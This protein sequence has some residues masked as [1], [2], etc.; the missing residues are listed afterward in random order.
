MGRKNSPSAKKELVT[1]IT[2]Y[3]EA[4][5]ENRQLYLDADQLA[6]IADWYA[7]ERK[8]EEAQEVITYG[9]KIHPRNTDLLI[10]QAY[11]YLDTQKLQKAKKVADSITEE[12]DSEVKLLKAELLLNGGKL[13]EAQWLLS[14]I[15]DADEL[16][17]IIDVVFLYLDMGYPD[18]AKEWLDRGKSRYAEDEEYMALTADYLA[19]THQ[20]ESAIIYYNKLIDKSPFNP[21]YWMGLVKCYFVQEQIDKAIEA[22]D[23]ALAADESDGEAYTTKAHSFFQLNNFDKSIENYKKAMEYK[24]ISPDMGYMFIGLCYGAKEDWEKANEYYDKVIDFL[25][26]SNG[27]ESALSID[28]YTNKANALAELG[29]YKEAHQTCKKISKIHPKDATILLTEG[30]IY[31]LER[32]LEKARICF[33]KL[34]DI[35][36]SIDM[37]YM[38]ACAYMENNYEIESQYYLEKVYAL[39]PKF[40]DVAEKL[41]V[42][43][44]AYGDIESFFKYNN[45][46]AHPVTEEALSDLINYACQ[47]EEQR[48]IFKKI[49]ARMKKEKKESK[50]N[51]GK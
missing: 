51:K 2:N 16:E 5:A 10:E 40:E 27:N 41:S 17:T 39:D 26:K 46:C 21:S 13:E 28:I 35:D 6:G 31:L 49:L 8:F 44:L 22:C 36:S 29:R 15:A 7:S 1:L 32:K 42:C 23:F 3:E 4:K 50:K 14:T 9:L 47:N 24:A 43:S 33:I 48:K 34:S 25:E 11:L 37:Y 19:S 18:A 38:I 12:F 30:K 45:D 20:V